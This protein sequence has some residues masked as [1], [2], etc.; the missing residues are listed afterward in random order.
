MNSKFDY[1]T[2]FI[3]YPRDEGGAAGQK[4]PRVD[5]GVRPPDP[6]RYF[7]KEEAALEWEHLS[8]IHI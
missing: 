8:L 2:G 4:A 3:N 6:R 5:L 1:E 7:S